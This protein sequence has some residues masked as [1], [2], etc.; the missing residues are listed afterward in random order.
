LIILQII[1]ANPTCRKRKKAAVRPWPL[2]SFL[3][4]FKTN[5]LVKNLLNRRRAY[6]S[7]RN[8]NRIGRNDFVFPGTSAGFGAAQLIGEGSFL[9]ATRKD[10]L[11]LR[12]YGDP[13]GVVIAHTDRFF[14]E[15]EKSREQ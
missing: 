2:P 11:V 13:H 7:R 12:H 5:G 4:L 10:G 9:V 14:L 3:S 8:L 1:I 6:I 15:K